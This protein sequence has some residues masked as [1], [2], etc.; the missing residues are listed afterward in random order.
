MVLS[1]TADAV[2]DPHA[3]LLTPSGRVRD[4]DDF[5]FYNAPR[6]PSGV[7]AIDEA[8][9]TT[10]T[11]RVSLPDVADDVERVMITASVDDGEFADLADVTAA[12]FDASHRVLEFEVKPLPSATAMILGEFFRDEGAWAFL[13]IGEGC[14]SG[15]AGLATKFGVGVEGHNDS[16]IEDTLSETEDRSSEID[17]DLGD[18]PPPL[19][20]EQAPGAVLST[21]VEDQGINDGDVVD[22]VL[23]LPDA[24]LV[25]SLGA[26]HTLESA[27]ADLIDNCIDAG[28]THIAVRLLTD[29]ARL[30]SVE[31]VD[32]G[33]GMSA[34][35][36]T[37]AMTIGHR[38]D[39]SETD[40]GHFGMGLKAASLGHAD[41]LTVWSRRESSEPVGRRIR[42]S[43]FSKNFMC[44]VLSPDAAQ[45]A[46][47]SRRVAVAG[48]SG[49]TIVWSNL[50]HG[51]RG[52][53]AREAQAWL[54]TAENNVRCHLGVVFHRLLDTKRTSRP[55]IDLHVDTV[56]DAAGSVGVPVTAIDPFGYGQTGHPD[57]PKSVCVRSGDI[58]VNLTCHIWPGKSDVTGFRIGGKPGEQYQGFFIYRNDRL[59]QI[60]GWSDIATPSSAR[61]LA[62]VVLDDSRAIGHLVTMNPEK[63]GM[64]FE[65]AFHDA[66]AQAISADGRRFDDFLADAESMYVESN[67]RRR[68][69]KP[70]IRPD[71]GFSPDLRKAIRSE[72]EMIDGE[73]VKLQWRRM[74]EGEFLD[75]DLPAKTL[76]LNSRYRPLFAPSR[77]SLNDAPVLKALLYLLTHRAFE[78]QKR[79]VVL[80]DE[81]ALWRA[82]LGAAV[83]NE[84]H[85]RNEPR[86]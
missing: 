57:Y 86:R 6:H 29:E 71:K 62:R 44:E 70:A 64:K 45:K 58:D 36:V 39:Y 15:L 61:Q 13:P 20:A 51:Y 69:R 74:P 22:R 40:L 17:R 54:S 18:V 10:A 24:G 50:R 16:C 14:I 25:A 66:I 52:R 81:I 32:N 23:L 8:T 31:V 72:L 37:S 12:V 82:V 85:I 53:N 26:N 11:L 1:W 83:V 67:K 5:V 59:L 38:R 75:V 47:E 73:P 46:D 28:A 80:N 79:G 34:S 2:V 30:V 68:V 42:R 48:A 41:V 19:G 55:R 56:A 3:L 63:Q 78:A 4:D 60:G 65:P 35:E 33:R 76:W 43:T 27:I 77:G 9:L 7:V 21:T 49:T 84:E